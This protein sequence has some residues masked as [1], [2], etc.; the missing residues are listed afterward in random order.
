MTQGGLNEKKS[1][2]T[3]AKMSASGRR[4]FARM[5]ADER[6]EYSR[7]T[8]FGKALGSKASEETKARISAS[9]K[10]QKHFGVRPSTAKFTDD[11]IRSIRLRL[12]NGLATQAELAQ[13]FGVSAAVMSGIALGKT[14][15]GVSQVNSGYT[16][17]P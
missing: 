5:S 8:G 2:E 6:A 15:K 3:R 14:Y 9:K 13:E 12:M 7:R 11:E 10:G 16:S 1:D 4:R 17:H